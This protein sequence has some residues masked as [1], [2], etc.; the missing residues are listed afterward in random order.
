MCFLYISRYKE[1]CKIIYYLTSF[2]ILLSDNYA[3]RHWHNNYKVKYY[4]T[5]ISIL[6]TSFLLET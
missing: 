6:L 1:A 3:N 2:F 5:P 4:K